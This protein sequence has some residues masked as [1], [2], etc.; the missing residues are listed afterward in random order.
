MTESVVLLHCAGCGIEAADA[1]LPCPVCCSFVFV[2]RR[3]CS[4]CSAPFLGALCARCFEKRTG[5]LEDMEAALQE[6]LND[7]QFVMVY[8]VIS[9]LLTRCDEFKEPNIQKYA[10]EVVRT[11]NTFREIVRNPKPLSL[12]FASMGSSSALDELLQTTYIEGFCVRQIRD[13]LE[14]AIS[15]ASD[16]SL[17]GEH[18]EALS[19]LE[20]FYGIGSQYASFR[21]LHG[22]LSSE[23]VPW[24]GADLREAISVARLE[25]RFQKVMSYLTLLV[26]SRMTD[27]LRQEANAQLIQAQSHVKEGRRLLKS[28][29]TNNAAASFSAALAC[30]ADCHEASVGL[31]RA[32]VMSRV[33]RQGNA[34]PAKPTDGKSQFWRSG[35]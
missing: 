7:N 8:E 30:V 1:A 4:G 24:D 31:C 35:R 14:L 18:S 19:I 10:D 17:I 28:G 15:K 12:A 29:D 9:K 11:G 13:D 27:V 16:L 5:V 22:K 32:S 25:R 34:A 6:A 3:C 21:R 23:Q 33:Q 2:R 26:P 20:E